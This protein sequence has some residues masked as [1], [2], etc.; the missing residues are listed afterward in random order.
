MIVLSVADIAPPSL[1]WLLEIRVLLSDVN[2]TVD[3][4]L[5]ITPPS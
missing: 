2:I 3:W 5:V 1:A 4:K